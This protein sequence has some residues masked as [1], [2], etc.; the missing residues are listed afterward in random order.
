MNQGR[1][2]ALVV[3]LG[4]LAGGGVG[5]REHG[6][7]GAQPRLT[8]TDAVILNR[9]HA[10]DT[11]EIEAGQMALTRGTVAGVHDFSR[12][13]VEDHTA[14]DQEVKTLAEAH[15]L[16]L[17]GMDD[18]TLPIPVQAQLQ[19]AHSAMTGL[20]YRQGS[21]FDRQYLTQMVKDHEQALEFLHTARDNT[22]HPAVAQLLDRTIPVVEAHREQA[23][24]LL[25]HMGQERVGRRGR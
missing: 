14:N 10:I 21:D 13:L 3:G 2:A 20:A 6:P 8:T 16:T 23:S 15:N 11:M 18:P 4:L 25:G 1:W 17:G 12:R 7:E 19:R 22:R 24:A 5:A 9:L